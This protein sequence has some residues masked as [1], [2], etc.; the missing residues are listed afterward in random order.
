MAGSCCLPARRSS[1]FHFF[2]RC[3]P[4]AGRGRCMR[5]A[6]CPPAAAKANAPSCHHAV[7]SSCHHAVKDCGIGVS[8]SVDTLFSVPLFV[9]PAWYWSFTYLVLE[10]WCAWT[11]VSL[12]F[13][14]IGTQ[15]TFLFYLNNAFSFSVSKYFCFG[16]F[17]LSGYSCS[18]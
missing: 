18:T 17:G 5:A 4:N 1:S 11:I 6:C 13:Y 8:V 9:P 7:M 15:H 14:W 16:C 3:F 12:A 2:F 10:C